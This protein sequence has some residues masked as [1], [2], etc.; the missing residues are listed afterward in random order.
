MQKAFSC[1]KNLNLNT[2]FNT[3]LSIFESNMSNFGMLSAYWPLNLLCYNPFHLRMCQTVGWDNIPLGG[4]GFHQGLFPSVTSVPHY[5]R[6]TWHFL[7]RSFI[8][9]ILG[10]WKMFGAFRPCFFSH[11]GPKHRK[12]RVVHF[13]HLLIIKDFASCCCFFYPSSMIPIIHNP[14]CTPCFNDGIIWFSPIPTISTR[15]LALKRWL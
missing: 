14:I 11:Y 10:S 2:F 9:I 3:K 7:G 6:W 12:W 15:S 4:N 8:R 5:D 1:K 13:I